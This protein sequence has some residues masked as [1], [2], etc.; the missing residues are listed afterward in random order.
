MYIIDFFKNLFKKS[1]IGT[2]IWM[3]MN[4]IVICLIF[5]L[6]SNAATAKDITIAV[7]VGLAAYAVSVAITLSPFGETIMRWQNGCRKIKDEEILA[8]MQPIFEEV[9]SAARIKNP[10]LPENVKLYMSKDKTPNAFAM[11]RHTVCFTE[12][13]LSMSDSDIKG[14][15]GHEF[16]HLAHKD[17]DTILVVTTG[18]LIV[19]VIFM[20]WRFFFNL[21][22]KITNLT[23]SIVN[24]SFGTLIA[25]MI[26]RIFIDFLLVAGMTLWTRLGVAICMSS[27]R[28]NEYL[29]DKYSFELGYGQDL[30]NALNNL[31]GSKKRSKGLWAALSSSHPATADRISKLTQML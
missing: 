24:N 8:R 5:V 14:I 15:L 19:S 16:G 1:N 4:A 11:G 7:L 2:I 26:T 10:E 12:G 22:I 29:A 17:T 23:L 13:L 3:I 9:Y 31:G 20:V 21:I 18:N 30:C 6:F 27:S 28:A 25:G